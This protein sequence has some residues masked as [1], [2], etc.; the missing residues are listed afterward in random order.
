MVMEAVFIVPACILNAF[1]LEFS[2][3]FKR[4]TKQILFGNMVLVLVLVIFSTIH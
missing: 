2:G 4:K 1:F 3:D